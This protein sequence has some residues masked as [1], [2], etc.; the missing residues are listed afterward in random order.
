MREQCRYPHFLLGQLTGFIGTNIQYHQLTYE[1]FIAGELATIVVTS[2]KSERLGRI[3]LLQKISSWRLRAGVT[4]PQVRNTYAHILG[5]IE[6]REDTWDVDWEKYECNIYGRV[7]LL[8]NTKQD[9]SKTASKK[10][11]NMY[12][13]KNYQKIE[14][15]NREPLH[16]GRVG[17]QIKSVQH[18][19]ATCWFKEKE[20]KKH[21]ESS[22]ECPYKEL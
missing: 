14:G 16:P 13:C 5:K 7:I 12:F 22:M 21:S 11:D 17:T 20:P 4:W 18:F 3:D 1:Q 6:D 9:K 8:P 19:C 2:N 15:C 10:G